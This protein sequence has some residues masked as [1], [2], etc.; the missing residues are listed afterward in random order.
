MWRI[1]GACACVVPFCVYFP[2]L[3]D[4]FL[5]YVMFYVL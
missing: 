1:G 2:G 4:V 3:F 5:R